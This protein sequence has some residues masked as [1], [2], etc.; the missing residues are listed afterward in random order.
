MSV[1]L[2]SVRDKKVKKKASSPS[3]IKIMGSGL[4]GSNILDLGTRWR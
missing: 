4:Y 2:I 3:A 1:T